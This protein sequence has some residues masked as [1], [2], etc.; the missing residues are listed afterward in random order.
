MTVVSV[1]VELSLAAGKLLLYQTVESNTA[2]VKLAQRLGYERYAQHVAVRRKADA[3]SKPPLPAE[4]G[5]PWGRRS[6]S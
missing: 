2:A 1:T 6:G 3:P 5:T 4:D